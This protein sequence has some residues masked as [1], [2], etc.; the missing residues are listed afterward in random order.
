MHGRHEGNTHDEA[1]SYPD[2][3]GAARDAKCNV[4]FSL[5]SMWLSSPTVDR[6]AVEARSEVFSSIEGF[7]NTRR[8][9]SALGY[10]APAN[11]EGINRAA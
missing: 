4:S 7:Y 1:V 2:A 10:Q 3:S 8:L 11:F 5:A 6:A 9:H